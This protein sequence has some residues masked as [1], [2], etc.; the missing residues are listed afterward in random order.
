MNLKIGAVK[1]NLLRVTSQYNLCNG[2]LT[3]TL[4]EMEESVAKCDQLQ[5]DLVHQQNVAKQR[6][7]ELV[8]LAKENA[9]VMK[10]RD[11]VQKRIQTLD[12]DKFELTKEVTKLRC[13]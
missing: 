9:H 13:V 6:D 2:K 11:A 5:I 7:A 8:R 12:A 3:K 1:A 10:T 4:A